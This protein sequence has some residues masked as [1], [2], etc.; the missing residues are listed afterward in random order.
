MAANPKEERQQCRSPA[1]SSARSRRSVSSP[2]SRPSPWAQRERPRPGRPTPSSPAPAARSS[3]PLIAQ[4]IPALGDAHGVHAQL[5]R[6]SA[7]AAGIA[8]ITARTVDFG[9]SDAPLSP[10]QFAACK[11]CVQIPWALAATVRLLQHPG[12]QEPAPPRRAR[13]SRRST[14]AGSR[15]GTTPRSRS[16]IRASE[17]ARPRDHRRAPLRRLGHDVQLHRLPLAASAGTWKSQVGNGHVGQLARRRRRQGQLRRRRRRRARRRARSATPTS[18]TLLQNHLNYCKLK[19]RSG[20]YAAP[21]AAQHRA[22]RPPLDTKPAADGSLSIVDPPKAKKYTNAYPISTYTYVIV[23]STSAKATELKKLH[24]LGASRT[25]RASGRSSSSQPLPHV[26]GQVRREGDQEDP[27]V[28]ADDRRDRDLTDVTDRPPPLH[29]AAGA[30]GRPRPAGRRGPGRP[31]RAGARRPDRLE[32][33]RRRPALASPPSG[34]ASSGAS[35]GIPSP[36]REVYGAG[37]F[38]FGTAVTSFAA[39]LLA[40]PLAIGIA[41]FLTELAPRGLRAPVTALVETLAAIPSVVI[42]LWGILVLGPVAPRRRRAVRSTRRFGFI[43]LFGARPG[44]GRA[45][46]RRSSC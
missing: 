42:G 29:G 16:S 19:N 10:D 4:W 33:G 24:Q 15:T 28:G 41:L 8:A 7:P 1:S 31:R 30:S 35:P 45:S 32:G 11:G 3:R 36:G 37:S 20:K 39:L 38:L 17:P 40:A 18:R 44:R 26:G 25:A 14:W 5:Q 12:L 27:L 22:R 2:R 43:P 21:G 34:S 13:R 6:R 46:S 23:P 9:A